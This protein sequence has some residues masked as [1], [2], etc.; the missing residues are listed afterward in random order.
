MINIMQDEIQ[1]SHRQARKVPVILE[2]IVRLGGS[3]S[4]RENLARCLGMTFAFLYFLIL[5]IPALDF[6]A[7]IEFRNPAL[8][9]GQIYDSRNDRV[10]SDW[11]IYVYRYL[12]VS[13][14]GREY[15]GES[16]SNQQLNESLPVAIEYISDRPE[17]SRI[18]NT[19]T[20]KFFTEADSEWPPLFT[21]VFSGFYIFFALIFYSAFLLGRKSSRIRKKKT[22]LELK[23]GRT[24]SADESFPKEEEAEG[25]EQTFPEFSDSSRT[26]SFVIHDSNEIKP[27]SFIVSLIS[28]LLALFQNAVKIFILA[29]IPVFLI[30]ILLSAS[31]L[32]LTAADPV[33]KPVDKFIFTKIENRPMS[34]DTFKKF[35]P[36]D[37]WPLEIYLFKSNEMIPL[38]EGS[39]VKE[40]DV[41]QPY[42]NL[43]ESRNLV[44]FSV[45]GNRNIS[46]LMPQLR[47]KTAPLFQDGRSNFPFSFKLDDAPNYEVFFLFSSENPFPA[48]I[49]DDI[50]KYHLDELL[51]E[52]HRSVISDDIEIYRI[53][54]IKTQ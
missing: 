30:L 38:D 21:I 19:S 27:H 44:L 13:E 22:L 6:S 52:D 18:K 37:P 43:K 4:L 20:S 8:A 23:Y 3:L 42:Y 31:G 15:Y 11:R 46:H 32:P 39:E 40:G 50:I 54:L 25:E 33:L 12:F 48:A 10:G 1:Y 14:N 53:M 2:L 7:Q 45:D 34:Y 47:I 16:Y 26:D 9:E 41:I 28:I 35:T 29:G 49:A 51:Q 36:E 5:F 24:P 17:R